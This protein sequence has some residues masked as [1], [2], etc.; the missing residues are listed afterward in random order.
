MPNRMTKTD[1]SRI[2]RT[3]TKAGHDTSSNSF[4]ARSQS[5]GDRNANAGYGGRSGSSGQ[6]GTYN[7]SG[8]SGN[9]AGKR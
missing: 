5:A 1:A 6:S 7:P 3:Q 9:V 2:Q 4:A 8:N